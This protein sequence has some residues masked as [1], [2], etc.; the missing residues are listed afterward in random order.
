MK[1][2]A[3]TL[4]I[5]DVDNNIPGKTCKDYFSPNNQATENAP[6]LPTCV[7]MTKLFRE[8]D[9]GNKLPFQ[10][11]RKGYTLPLADI[12]NILKQNNSSITGIKVYFGIDVDNTGQRTLQ[13]IAIGTFDDGTSPFSDYNIPEIGAANPNIPENIVFGNLKPCPKECGKNNVL[14]AG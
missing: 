3:F 12:Q 9:N 8:V 11:H 7:G 1:N 13:L 6:D 14:N 2:Q 4:A 10:I 5:K